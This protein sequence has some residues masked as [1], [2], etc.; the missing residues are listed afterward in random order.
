MQAVD[1]KES[2][3]A[4]IAHMMHMLQLGEEQGLERLGAASAARPSGL[5][6]KR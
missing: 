1:G 2:E 5:Y 3:V 6:L 4:S